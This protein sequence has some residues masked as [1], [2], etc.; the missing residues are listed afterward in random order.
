MSLCGEKEGVK[1]SEDQIC[2]C[3]SNL[4]ISLWHVEDCDLCECNKVS[5]Y[6]EHDPCKKNSD[7]DLGNKNSASD[8]TATAG[9]TMALVSTLIVIL[10]H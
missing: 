9:A 7:D 5:E 3:D 10:L 8:K 4:C 6:S 2:R 1:L